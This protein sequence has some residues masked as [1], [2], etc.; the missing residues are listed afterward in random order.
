MPDLTAPAKP[1]PG[2]PC[3]GCGVCCLAETCPIGR[4]RFLQ[5]RGPCPALR[6]RDERYECGLLADAGPFKPLIARWIAAGKGCDSYT[7]SD[8]KARIS[9]NGFDQSP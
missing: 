4:I 6:W 5:I 9:A 2:A 8:S 7:M 3:N 1:A